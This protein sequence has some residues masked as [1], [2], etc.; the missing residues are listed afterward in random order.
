MRSIVSTLVMACLAQTAFSETTYEAEQGVL[1]N[2]A[3]IQDSSTSSGGKQV[4]R[5]G[6]EQNGTVTFNHLRV[7]QTGLYPARVHSHVGDDRACTLTVNSN[8]QAEVRDAE[9]LAERFRPYYKF[10]LDSGRVE[11]PC[12]P[13]SWQ[14]FAAHS[15][16]FHGS[17]LLA[18]AKQLQDAPRLLLAVADGNILTAKHPTGPLRLR[19][20][21]IVAA[22]EPWPSVIDTGAGL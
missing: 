7:S 8:A 19:P 15:D 14:W 6:G 1:S 12:R 20:D 17:N 16:L 4:P 5:I 3:T 2:G 13:C 22:G 18:T 9:P 21:A 11:E 10:S